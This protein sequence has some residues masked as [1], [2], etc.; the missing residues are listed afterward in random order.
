MRE[1]WMVMLLL[2]YDS[3]THSRMLRV[4]QKGTK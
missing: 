1:V 3:T 4:C 2:V